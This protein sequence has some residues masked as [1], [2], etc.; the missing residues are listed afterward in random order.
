MRHKPKAV[1]EPVAVPKLPAGGTTSFARPRAE[2]RLEVVRDRQRTAK[3]PVSQPAIPV[4]TLGPLRS[5]PRMLGSPLH[6]LE[7][8]DSWMAISISRSFGLRL[9]NLRIRTNSE[10]AVALGARAFARGDQIDFAPGAFDPSTAEGWRIIGHELAHV[11]QQRLGRVPQFAGIL[12]DSELEREAHAAGDFAAAVFATGRRP[13]SPFYSIPIPATAQRCAVQCLMS[14]VDFK[15]KSSASGRRDKIWKIDEALDAFHALN[16]QKPR[17]YGTLLKALEAL[18]ALCDT[19]LE[20]NPRS[21]RNAGVNKLKREIALEAAVIDPLAASANEAD[22]IRKWE[23]LEQ[24]QEKVQDLKSNPDFTRAFCDVEITDLIVPLEAQAGPIKTSGN[25]ATMVSRDVGLLRRLADSEGLPST[26]KSII[27]EA[28]NPANIWKVDFKLYAPGASY[29]TAS[30]NTGLKYTLK[31]KLAHRGLKWRLGF[32]ASRADAHFDRRDLQ[33]YRAD[34]GHPE[35]C[36]RQGN[37]GSR[38][39]AQSQARASAAQDRGGHRPR[40]PPGRFAGAG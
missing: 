8:V 15:T 19:Y 40:R 35:G 29:N 5:P 37:P 13:Q 21:D 4:P 6:F 30:T 10:R 26:L 24:A 23:Y 17:D 11:V 28:T 18:S 36:Q 3:T 27:E 2:P 9:D 25:E 34:A 38:A 12:H 16:K 31:H 7:V 14:L 32:F 1:A 22:L 20:E 33:Q 39:L